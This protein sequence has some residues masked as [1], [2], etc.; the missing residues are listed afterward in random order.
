MNRACAVLVLFLIGS[1]LV[2][3]R[4]AA[5]QTKRVRGVVWIQPAIGLSV[6]DDLVSGR[7]DA[8]VSVSDIPA[9]PLIGS[10]GA[11]LP[12]RA[13]VTFEDPVGI[14]V[15]GELTVRRFGIEVN[16]IY[17]PA[18]ATALG[19]VPVCGELLTE[20]QCEILERGNILVPGISVPDYVI[21][22]E[23]LANAAVTVGINYHL[24]PGKR[25]DV[26]AGPM[27]VWSIWDEYDFSDVRVDVSSS[28]ESLLKGEV[29]QFDL[30]G[31]AEIAPQNALTFGVAIGGRY[32]FAGSWSLLGQLRYFAGDDLVLPGGSGRYSATGFS[33]G[34]ARRFG[35]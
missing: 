6:G 2:P 7:L 10:V 3:G 12:V 18:A 29:D 1:I 24:A 32:D 11:T 9:L 5:D 26:W 17:L 16:V 21:V 8:E 25:W 19:S 27:L 31:T 23:E 30:A 33:A 22:E 35:G 20:A 13:D 4:S 14:L 34:I 28:L 15:G